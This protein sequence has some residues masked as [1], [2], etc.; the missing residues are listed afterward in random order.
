MNISLT[1]KL[2]HEIGERKVLARF[3]TGRYGALALTRAA[4]EA[5]VARRRGDNERYALL[6]GVI[7]DLRNT[8]SFITVDSVNA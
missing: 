4:G 3:L 8:I 6:E 2:P 5:A 1:S 7:A